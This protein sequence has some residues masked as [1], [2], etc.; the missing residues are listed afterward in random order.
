MS[1]STQQLTGKVLF[2]DDEKNILNAVRREL[3]DTGLDVF[4]AQNAEQGLR[5]LDEEDVDIVVS[6]FRMAGTDGLA[7]LSAIRKAHPTTCRV[8]LSGLVDQQ[9]VI[10]ALSTGVAGTYLPKP[11]AQDEL[12]RVLR[13]VLLTKQAMKSKEMLEIVNS[14]DELPALPRVY[15]EFVRAV[16]EERSYDELA[17]IVKRDV[18]TSTTLLRLATSAYYNQE[19][20]G[21]SV[22][23]A[24]VY[25]GTNAIKEMLLFTSLVNQRKWDKRQTAH[26]RDVSIHSMSVNYA[27]HE[28]YRIRFGR[29][30]PEHFASA[31]ITHDVGKIILLVHC[32]TQYNAVTTHMESNPGMGF[33]QSELALGFEGRTH[34]EFGAFFLDLW[35][36]PASSVE[37]CL[38]HHTEA[39]SIEYPSEAF[40]VCRA[41]DMLANFVARSPEAE[42][43]VP[44]FLID[45][46]D[47]GETAR[48]ISDLRRRAQETE[49]LLT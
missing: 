47:A 38:Y 26:L 31:G 22:E 17:R 43:T 41:A 36:L 2:V 35:G 21:L 39:S 45:Q 24:I 34:A 40:D 15:E 33:Y 9:T 14:I 25:I 3:V 42:N 7:F 19:K 6:D 49:G 12:Q 20:S 16:E 5:I 11:W 27:M 23:R 44:P 10:K 29:S 1:D 37:A 46:V 48:L 18:A 13:H 4:V 30:L 28:I 32:P 8:I